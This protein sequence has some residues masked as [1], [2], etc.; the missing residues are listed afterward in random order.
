MDK[1]IIQIRSDLIGGATP[2][3]LKPKYPT[4]SSKVHFWNM[5]TA[6]DLDQE[7]LTSLVVLQEGIDAGE[8]T[9]NDAS[10]MF[11]ELLV[12]KFVKGKVPDS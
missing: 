11:G 9:E 5:I 12:N 3:Q 7:V 4:L 2:E 6:K 10:I 1:L 8:F